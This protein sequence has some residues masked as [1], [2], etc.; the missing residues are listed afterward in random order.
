MSGAHLLLPEIAPSFYRRFGVSLVSRWNSCYSTITAFLAQIWCCFIGLI[1]FVWWP[2]SSC[3]SRRPCF[4][5]RLFTV[6]S[7]IRPRWSI[8]TYQYT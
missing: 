1:R 8:Y 6:P 5:C 3:I 7:S 4:F 2:A